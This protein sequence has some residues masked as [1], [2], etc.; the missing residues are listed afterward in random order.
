MLM[1]VADDSRN[2]VSE[3]L[4]AGLSCDAYHPTAP[5]PEGRGAYAAMVSALNDAGLA[6]SDVDYINLHGT[7]TP[8]NDLAEARAVKRLFGDHPPPVS[9][10]KGAAGHPLAAAGALAA[11][12][13]L[14]LIFCFD[15]LEPSR[16][17]EE[18]DPAGPSVVEADD[19]LVEQPPMDEAEMILPP[20][21]GGVL[22]DHP[23]KEFLPPEEREEQARR[24]HDPAA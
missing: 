11:V 1:L 10:F 24:L 12:L 21:G 9:S 17:F 15:L 8:D 23:E 19:A 3:L 4:G 20:D 22:A 5:H 18:V 14:F 2:A 16:P 13:I 6:T 7:G